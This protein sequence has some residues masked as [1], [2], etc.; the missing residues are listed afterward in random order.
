MIDG[1]FKYIGRLSYNKKNIFIIHHKG[2]GGMLVV[3]G[4]LDWPFHYFMW[5]EQADEWKF[6]VV[7]DNEYW[8][9]N[10]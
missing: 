1:S 3:Q 5:L 7:D 6:P 4:S 9:E 8:I 2:G 10:V